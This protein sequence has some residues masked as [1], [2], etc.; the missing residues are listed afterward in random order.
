MKQ[1]CDYVRGLWYK[2]IIMGIPVEDPTYV[3]GD[4]QYLLDNTTMPESTLKNESNTIAL[5]F[6]REGSARD[7]WRKA[8]INK[9]IDFADMMTNPLPLG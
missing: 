5:H 9:N 8:Y 1:A 4:N 3:Y 7:E 6:V 2:L